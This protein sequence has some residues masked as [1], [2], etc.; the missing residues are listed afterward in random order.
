MRPVR[1]GDGE[2]FD[3]VEKLLELDKICHQCVSC[4]LPIRGTASNALGQ[5]EIMS[6]QAEGDSPAGLA[7]P[8]R[9]LDP[10]KTFLLSRR[11]LR[12]LWPNATRVVP[13]H[14]LEL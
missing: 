9:N 4:E 3:A 2:S 11:S 8:R 14:A 12:G 13:I 10:D 1:R 6:I 7:D 5:D